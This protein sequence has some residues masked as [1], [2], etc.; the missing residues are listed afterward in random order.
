MYSFLS[1]LYPGVELLD[2]RLFTFLVS[3]GASKLLSKAV[4]PN[5]LLNIYS[6]SS[7]SQAEIQA[8]E[9]QLCPCRVYILV[10]KASQ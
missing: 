7:I 4:V 8:L 5:H 1:G 9:T 3:I 6:V 2:Y 10:D